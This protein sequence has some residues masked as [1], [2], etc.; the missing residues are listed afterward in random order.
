MLSKQDFLSPMRSAI[1]DVLFGNSKYSQHPSNFIECVLGF[2]C[3]TVTYAKPLLAQ[4]LPETADQK[5]IIVDS[6]LE[7]N[8]GLVH[9]EAQRENI[10]GMPERNFFYTTRA[11]STKS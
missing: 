9:I 7:T 5:Y 2:P 11:V 10:L 1:F 6:F 4:I 8:A 3:G